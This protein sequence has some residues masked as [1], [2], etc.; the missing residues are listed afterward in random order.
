MLKKIVSLCSIAALLNACTGKDQS[1]DN[2]TSKSNSEKNQVETTIQN[3]N[4]VKNSPIDQVYKTIDSFEDMRT[5]DIKQEF[6]SP[7]SGKSQAKVTITYGG[8]ADDSISAERE[9]YQFEYINGEW[10]EKSKEK[11]WKCGRGSDTTNFNTQLC[12]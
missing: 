8:L 1:Q 10:K 11:S 3:A 12:P 7:E 4:S 2:Q 5:V 6:D 9:T